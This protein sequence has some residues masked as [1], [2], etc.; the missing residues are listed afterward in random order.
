MEISGVQSET[1]VSRAL[2][3]LQKEGFILVAHSHGKYGPNRYL[4]KLHLL[5]NK[6]PITG[7]LNSNY[8]SLKL[9]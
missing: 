1:T 7:V 8:W 2:K 3:I 6:T 4:L 5:E 9:R